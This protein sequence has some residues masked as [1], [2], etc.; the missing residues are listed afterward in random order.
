M[1]SLSGAPAMP[2]ECRDSTHAALRTSHDHDM[3]AAATFAEERLQEE[4]KMVRKNRPHG[5]F[6]RPV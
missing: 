5:F 4:R 6:A 3:A 2:K 1:N